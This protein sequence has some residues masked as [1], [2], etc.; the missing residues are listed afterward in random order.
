MITKKR[1]KK[2]IY[3][4]QLQNQAK[5]QQTKGIAMGFHQTL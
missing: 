5:V 3:V 4:S 2:E 1:K